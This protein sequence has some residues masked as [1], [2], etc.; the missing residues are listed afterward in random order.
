MAWDKY[1]TADSAP[2][3]HLVYCDLVNDLINHKSY[4]QLGLPD[5]ELGKVGYIHIF[6][7]TDCTNKLWIS[8][9]I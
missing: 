6:V 9:E 5:T 1:C 2:T 7:F 4:L 8:K 3:I